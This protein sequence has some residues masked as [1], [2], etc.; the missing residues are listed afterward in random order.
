MIHCRP[1]S[2]FS[3]HFDLSGEGHRMSLELGWFRESGALVVDGARFD[4]VKPSLFVG[5]WSLEGPD[6]VH[7]RA[8][9][10]SALTRAYELSGPDGDLRLEPESMF[11]RAFQLTNRGRRLARLAPKAPIFRQATIEGKLKELDPATLAFAFWLVLVS[12]KRRGRRD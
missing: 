12:W 8:H 10:V 4:I 7:S 1:R 3:W 5:R 11:L 9:K 2:P 6:G